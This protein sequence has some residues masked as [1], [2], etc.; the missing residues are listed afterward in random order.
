MIEKKFD[1]FMWGKIEMASIYDLAIPK[2]RI[3]YFKYHTEVVW[4]KKGRIDK[5]FGSSGTGGETITDV[6]DRLQDEIDNLEAVDES[7]DI[8]LQARSGNGCKTDRLTGQGQGHGHGL[9]PTHFICIPLQDP[10]IRCNIHEVQKTLCAQAQY[11]GNDSERV[12]DEACVPLTALHLTLVMLRLPTA[13]AIRRAREV[14]RA[15]GDLLQM[16][17]PRHL[18]LTL[19]GVSDFGGRVVFTSPLETGRLSAL[20]VAMQD[21]LRRVGVALPGNHDPFQPHVTIAKM[22]R[23]LSR[24]WHGA[25]QLDHSLYGLHHDLR[26]GRQAVQCI[27]LCEL[28]AGKHAHTGFYRSVDTVINIDVPWPREGLGEGG[29]SALAVIAHAI[30][31]LPE[32]PPPHL[33]T[34]TQ[35]ESGCFLLILR[36]LPG[37][38]KSSLAARIVSA[39][40]EKYGGGSTCVSADKYMY[41]EGRTFQASSLS[42]AHARCLQT[43]RDTFQTLPRPRPCL[44]VLD[45]TNTTPAE[46]SAYLSLCQDCGAT[47]GIVEMETAPSVSADSVLS[48]VV[49]CLSSDGAVEVARGGVH[50]VPSDTVRRMWAR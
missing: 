38:G 42:G 7:A 32:V 19:E 1:E 26:V 45:N 29:G 2:H 12:R 31:P 11:Q 21:R 40:D 34:H 15:M 24:D 27:Q 37:S 16:Y 4:S 9:R 35:T 25:S 14:F 10:H 17:T 18:L 50:S 39:W 36:G 48:S 44:V 3:E 6:I 33:Q 47:V 28:Y 49:G 22:S 30:G 13:E 5:V 23:G 41:R 20:V 8:P 46:Y 43:V